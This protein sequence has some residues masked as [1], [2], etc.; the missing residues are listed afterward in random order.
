MNTRQPSPGSFDQGQAVMTMM[1]S[2]S[3]TELTALALAVLVWTV[4]CSDP[5][6]RCSSP[7]NLC[8][9]TQRPW[10]NRLPIPPA[11]EPGTNSAY[12]GADYYE[13]HV[14]QFRQ[15][16][17][18]YAAGTSERIYTTVWGY[19]QVGHGYDVGVRD[20]DGNPIPQSGMYV[21]PTFLAERGRPVVVKWIDDRANPEGAPLT[22]HLLESSYDS[23]IPGAS[24]GEPHVRMVTH[25]HGAEVS[26]ASDGYPEFWYT[27]DPAA[28]ANGLGGPAGNFAIDTYPNLQQATALWYHDH[29]MGI[30]RLNVMSIGAGFYLIRDQAQEAGLGLPGGDYEIPLAI[31][32]RMFGNDGSLSYLNSANPPATSYHPN[33]SPEFFG[34]VITVNGMAWPYLEVEPRKYRFRILN[35]SNARMYNLQLVN[36]WT[37]ELWPKVWQI[38]TDGGYLSA[39]VPLDMPSLSDLHATERSTRLFLAPGERADVVVDFSGLDPG[40]PLILSNDAPSPFPDGDAPDPASTGKILQFRVVPLKGEDTSILPAQLNLLPTRIDASQ[41]SVVRHLV[42]AEI[43]DPLTGAPVIGLLNNTC[44]DQ[45]LTEDPRLGATE[46]WEIANA[47]GDTHPIH[48]HLVQFNLLNWQF[49]EKERYLADW[50][51]AS[52]TAGNL[53]GPPPSC[54]SD[55][56]PVTPPGVAAGAQEILPVDEY[57]LGAP[58]SAPDNEAG[59]KDTVRVESGTVTRLLIR[60]APQDA[61]R[62]GPYGGFAFD[63]TEGRY[64]W[65]CHILEHED[66]GMMRPYQIAK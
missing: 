47:T 65:H 14:T 48:L 52:P 44:F 56:E 19:G 18:L 25:L 20:Q 40:A 62:P 35:A 64:V 54:S 11:F 16:F 10:S 38:G 66:N 12:P 24:D 5:K 49:I 13:I 30:T 43:E 46:I 23:T 4:G 8:S 1:R 58:L 21:A 2:Y 53:P 51:A 41:A 34:D 27:P 61:T 31:A 33:W 9:E 57:L 45:P 39:P 28:S 32:D 59:W 42:L 36:L 15:W 22:T 17:G 6:R 37:K 29:A 50:N 63:P 60:F 7:D 55:S 3:K 26:P